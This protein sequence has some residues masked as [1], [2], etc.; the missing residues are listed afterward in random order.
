MSVQSK[1]IDLGFKVCR[2]KLLGKVFIWDRVPVEGK[3]ID[4][5]KRV[6]LG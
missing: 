3:G 2:F 1:A 6:G 4:L 5:G